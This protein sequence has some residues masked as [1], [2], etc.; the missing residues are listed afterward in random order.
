MAEWAQ[1]RGKAGM[2]RKEFCAMK[3]IS[4][5][6]FIRAQDRFRKQSA[7]RADDLA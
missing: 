2:T 3:R 5:R 1:V 6:S 7:E 4:L